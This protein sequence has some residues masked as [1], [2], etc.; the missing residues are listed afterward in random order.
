M[1]QSSDLIPAHVVIVT[2]WLPQSMLLQQSATVLLGPLVSID[3][4][5]CV[6]SELL[7]DF[8]Y[9]GRCRGF[10]KTHVWRE[11]PRFSAASSRSEGSGLGRIP[12]RYP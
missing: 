9:E 4:F 3:P 7:T 1:F 10:S 5:D 8:G 11:P 2:P 6:L 12:C